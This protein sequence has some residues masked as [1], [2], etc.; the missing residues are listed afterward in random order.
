[1]WFYTEKASLKGLKPMQKVGSRCYLWN[2]I[3]WANSFIEISRNLNFD[4]S[5]NG[6]I[7][8][9]ITKNVI[10]HWKNGL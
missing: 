1:M 3:K 6:R 10:L 2:T 4:G 7:S 5:K 9:K 8:L